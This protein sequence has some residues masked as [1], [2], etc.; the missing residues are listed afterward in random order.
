MVNKRNIQNTSTGS[1]NK[2]PNYQQLEQQNKL[3]CKELALR[4]QEIE[5]LKKAAK[6]LASQS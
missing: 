1:R 3:M 2:K 6:Y 4:K 5:I